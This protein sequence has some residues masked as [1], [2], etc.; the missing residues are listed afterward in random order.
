MNNSIEWGVGGRG[1]DFHQVPEV[2]VIHA[3]EPSS[4]GPSERGGVTIR[5]SS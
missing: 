2:E 5:P 3:I 1:F 4:S